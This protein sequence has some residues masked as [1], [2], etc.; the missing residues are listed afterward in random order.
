MGGLDMHYAPQERFCGGL[1]QSIDKYDYVGHIS[2]DFTDVRRQVEEMMYLTLNKSHT[3]TNG[4]TQ[5]DQLPESVDLDIQS[6]IDQ[7]FPPAGP[8][9]DAHHKLTTDIM[10][11]S[12]FTPDTLRLAQD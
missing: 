9:Q 2:R 5:L 7:S 10:L 8:K 4:A 12:Y 6:A 1:L 3:V 11:A